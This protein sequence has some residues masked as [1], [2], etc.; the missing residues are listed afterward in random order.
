MFFFPMLV[1]YLQGL[2]IVSRHRAQK[3]HFPEFNFFQT[4]YIFHAFL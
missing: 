1:R 3:V 2:K 4:L